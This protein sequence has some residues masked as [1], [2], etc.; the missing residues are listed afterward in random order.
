MKYSARSR[1]YLSS[2][3]ILSLWVSYLP[4]SR[5]L[6]FS[7]RPESRSPHSTRA[8]RA[9][10]TLTKADAATEQR[11]RQAYGQLPVSFEPNR[12]QLDSRVKFAA[13]GGGYAVFLTATE[14]VFV[15]RGQERASSVPINKVQRAKAPA[16]YAQ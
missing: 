12:G 11:V 6:A 13:R 16:T 14:A 10:A 8:A 3:L 9:G 2:M 5:V 1:H 4:A 7:P 15:L